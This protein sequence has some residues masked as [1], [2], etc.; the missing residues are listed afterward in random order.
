MFFPSIA[1]SECWSVCVLC[2][3]VCVCVCEHRA[4][5]GVFSS[6]PHLK[7]QAQGRRICPCLFPSFP[8]L[9]TTPHHTTPCLDNP[10]CRVRRGRAVSG[11]ADCLPS[12][13]LLLFS[14]F[15]ISAW[16]AAQA[17]CMHQSKSSTDNGALLWTLFTGPTTNQLAHTLTQTHKKFSSVERER[18]AHQRKQEAGDGK[19]GGGARGEEREGMAGNMGD[20]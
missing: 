19:G 12:N 5:S 7:I 20:R 4:P 9:P 17:S 6:P 11:L 13:L 14:V 16:W 10:Q 3:C 2:V 15:G 18:G 1:L 8:L